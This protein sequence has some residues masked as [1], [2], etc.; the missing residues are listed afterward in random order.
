[1]QL[2]FQKPAQLAKSKHVALTFASP[3]TAVQLMSELRKHLT[4][5]TDSLNIFS[6]LHQ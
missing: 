4:Q 6:M 1:M 5:T 2:G 3:A